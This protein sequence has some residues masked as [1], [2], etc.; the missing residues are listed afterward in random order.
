VVAQPRRV[1]PSFVERVRASA[2]NYGTVLLL[3]M[4]SFV[5]PAVVPA[6]PVWLAATIGFLCL[7]ILVSLHSSRVPAWLFWTAAVFSV[8]ATLSML[9]AFGSPLQRA[10]VSLGLGVLL[11]V[12]PVAI[13]RRIARHQRITGKTVAGAI[14]VYLQF[15]WAFAV[16]YRT[17]DQLSNDQALSSAT[18]MHFVAYTYFSF[19]T[20]TTLGYG[21][22]VPLTDQART[23]VIFESVLG[24]VFLVTVVAR[25]VSLMGQDRGMSAAEHAQLEA[26]V[27]SGDADAEALPAGDHDRGR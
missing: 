23:A 19:V 5:L 3:L 6:T 22:I 25:V 7:S 12:S 20:L 21:D 26:D 9:N 1:Q 13:L 27:A 4:V 17:L 18:P 14:A 24:Q 11:I 2:D 8:L 10:F 15:G 16:L